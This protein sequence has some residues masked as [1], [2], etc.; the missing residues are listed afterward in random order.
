MPEQDSKKG[1]PVFLGQE[2]DRSLKVR[3]R[4]WWPGSAVIVEAAGPKIRIGVR[5]IG[6][7]MRGRPRGIN[8]DSFT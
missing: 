4:T 2:S 8:R 3:S 7:R 6:T 1:W 5:S